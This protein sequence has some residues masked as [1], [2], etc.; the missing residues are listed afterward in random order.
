MRPRAI[1]R[2][3]VCRLATSRGCHRYDG[4]ETVSCGIPGH[5]VPGEELIT[6]ELHRRGRGAPVRIPRQLRVRRDVRLR[7]RVIRRGHLPGDAARVRARVGRSSLAGRSLRRKARLRRGS[8]LLL[9]P[10]RVHSRALR[11]DTRGTR[12][13]RG[14][15]AGRPPLPCRPRERR[16]RSG[17]RRVGVAGV[18]RGLRCDAAADHGRRRASTPGSRWSRPCATSSRADPELRSVREHACEVPHARLL[19]GQPEQDP[20][21]DTRCA[22]KRSP[23]SA[24]R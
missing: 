1:G 24:P 21:F 20:G 6:D 13:S 17:V 15:G 14:R 10:E 16:P 8:W 22:A 12:G 5:H 19:L 4:G 3:S 9:H 23:A 11:S 7:R 18:V 2:G